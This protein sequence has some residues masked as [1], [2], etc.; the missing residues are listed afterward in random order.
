MAY[1][2][3][4]LEAHTHRQSTAAANLALAE[5]TVSKLRAQL[6]SM[7]TELAYETSKRE[8][9]TLT[10]QKLNRYLLESEQRRD[11]LQAEAFLVEPMSPLTQ[12]GLRATSGFLVADSMLSRRVVSGRPKEREEW[13]KESDQAHVAVLVL[14]EERRQSLVKKLTQEHEAQ[15]AT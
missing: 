4:R 5:E 7:K 3:T 11:I 8:E 10:T 15:M 1:G 9:L 14:E 12:S 2:M 13:V 6:S